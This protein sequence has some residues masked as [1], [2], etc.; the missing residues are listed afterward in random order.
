[1]NVS[2]NG[3]SPM[4]QQDQRSVRN[5]EARIYTEQKRIADMA[6][7]IEAGMAGG[8]KMVKS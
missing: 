6:E 5:V 3:K 7:L 2:T 4:V 1:M 8:S